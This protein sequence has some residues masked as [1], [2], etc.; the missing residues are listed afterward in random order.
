MK[1]FDNKIRT[2][3]V[4]IVVITA[5]IVIQ[6]SIINKD[7]TIESLELTNSSQQHP[8]ATT[9]EMSEPVP[10]PI[11]G[12]EGIIAENTDGSMTYTILGEYNFRFRYPA[13]WRLGDNHIDYG[14]FQIFNYD[15]SQAEGGDFRADD[16]I[17]K[18]EAVVMVYSGYQDSDIYPAKI[19]TIE[20]L[21]VAGQR[22]TREH[23][24]LEK[25]GL[26]V[27]SYVVPI[28]NNDKSLVISIYGNPDNFYILDDVMKS[29]EWLSE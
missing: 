23:T 29:L 14:T 15:S 27:V 5:F 24:K 6:L 1:K 10:V 28:K 9:P 4:L 20:Y 16:K 17:N 22:S 12:T 7:K 26:E 3:V 11:M 8:V 18:I 13:G 2:I 21:N 25:G 19:R